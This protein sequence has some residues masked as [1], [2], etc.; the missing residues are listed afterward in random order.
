VRSK[1]IEPLVGLLPVKTKNLSLDYK[2]RRFVTGANY[3]EVARHHIWFGSF[4]PEEQ[5]HY[6][7]QC[8][9]HTDSDIY[10]QAREMMQECAGPDLL[11][12][13]QT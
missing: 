8:V 6:L 9:S 5:L 1:L 2:A 3:D 7:P 4:T 12:R 13:M 11:K 10:K